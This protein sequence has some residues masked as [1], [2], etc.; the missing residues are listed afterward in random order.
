[1]TFCTTTDARSSLATALGRRLL[2]E[3]FCRDTN[4]IAQEFFMDANHK[5]YSTIT[6]NVRGVDATCYRVLINL[7]TILDNGLQEGLAMAL[8]V[9]HLSK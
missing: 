7:D 1:M 9:V 3:V 2:S 5:F 6:Q 4:I 8:V